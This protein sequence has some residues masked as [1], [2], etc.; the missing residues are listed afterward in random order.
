MPR[1]EDNEANEKIMTNWPGMTSETPGS[2]SPTGSVAVPR[3][4]SNEN[5]ET[6]Q[7]HGIQEEERVI[8]GCKRI[9]NLCGWIHANC[10]LIGLITL[11]PTVY[12]LGYISNYCICDG[13]I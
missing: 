8:A 10:W 9:Y 4:E 3:V 5:L 2:P 11:Y 13:S 7:R 12:L 6:Y 1:A